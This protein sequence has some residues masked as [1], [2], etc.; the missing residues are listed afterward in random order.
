[1]IASVLF[2]AVPWR[3]ENIKEQHHT[4]CLCG[5]W[6]YTRAL[7]HLSPFLWFIIKVNSVAKYT[8]S[9]VD[10]LFIVKRPW[11]GMYSDILRCI[12]AESETD[13]GETET[14]TEKDIHKRQTYVDRQRNT[15]K[16]TEINSHT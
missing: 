13:R 11:R 5:I 2:A 12:K 4:H 14:E 9:L 7:K 6:C 10:Y 3:T 15:Q 16:T 8:S 1:M